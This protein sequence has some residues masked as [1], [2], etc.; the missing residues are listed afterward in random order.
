MNFRESVQALYATGRFADIR[1]EAGR[2]AD[3]KVALSFHT[4]PNYFIG[5]VSVEGNPSH[6]SA[7]Q[8]V[9]SSKL[10]LGEL[11]SRENMDRAV[12]IVRQLM[13]PGGERK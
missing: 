6:P 5:D 8:V 1:A 2:T 11:F 4:R 13:Q 12:E 7:G 3:G 9:N 10:N